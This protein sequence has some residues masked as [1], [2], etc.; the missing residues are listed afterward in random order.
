LNCSFRIGKQGALPNVLLDALARV[1]SKALQHGLEL[2]SIIS[3]LEGLKEN[4]FWFKLHD[5][6]EKS[7]QAESVVDAIS[8]ILDFNYNN[9]IDSDT[10][11]TFQVCPECG[12][13]GLNMNVGCKSGLCELCGYT[14]CS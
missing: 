9:C 7:T 6:A 14:S 10:N 11:S 5:E 1:C 8:K 12:K 3:T 2:D 13:R 4:S